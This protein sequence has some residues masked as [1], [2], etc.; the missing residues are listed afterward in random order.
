MSSDT[1]TSQSVGRARRALVTGGAGF[2]GSHLVDGLLRAGWLVRVLDDLSTGDERNLSDV[3][4]RIEFIR[5]SV[6]DEETNQRAMQDVEVV[7]HEAALPSVPKS[8]AQPLLTHN[9]NLSGTLS[10]LE[11]ARHS[12]V[13][14]VIFAASSS[15]YG[16]TQ[17]LPKVETLPA[18]PQSPYA[19][20]K[21][22][23]EVYCG[24]YFRLYGLETV[25]LRY[26]NIFGPRQNPKSDYAAVIPS[27]VSAALTGSPPVIFGDGE[28]TRDFTFV[29]NAV[30]ANLAA[31]DAP[32]AP[33]QVINV[34]AG[35]RT[36]LNELWSGIK[37]LVGVDVE[38]RYADKRAGDVRDSLAD[39]TRAK[40]LLGYEPN[41]DLREGLRRTIESLTH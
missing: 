27:F 40:E 30:Q 29:E 5:G 9:V 25:A 4:S 11:S 8:V 6:C 7:F 13:R 19:L 15:A 2:I 10:V 37:T 3:S 31:V 14:R 33:G 16:D 20:Q 24:L 32:G 36:S 28:Q 38:A 23:S 39:L 34:A 22:S 41:I 18:T 26:F 17:V 21:Y 35:Q 1:Q 12:G